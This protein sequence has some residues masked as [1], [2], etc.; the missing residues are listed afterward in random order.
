MIIIKK[1]VVELDVILIVM[2]FWMYGDYGVL[3]VIL[4]VIK[5][6]K[7]YYKRSVYIGILYYFIFNMLFICIVFFRYLLDF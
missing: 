7:L 2:L 5:C 3:N 1:I 4:I 6:K